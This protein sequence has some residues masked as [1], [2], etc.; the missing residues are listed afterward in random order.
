[1]GGDGVRNGKEGVPGGVWMC[2]CARPEL[3]LPVCEQLT[4]A[5]TLVLFPGVCSCPRVSVGAQ[6]LCPYACVTGGP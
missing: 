4:Q 6:D 3:K 2:M 1:M 5:S